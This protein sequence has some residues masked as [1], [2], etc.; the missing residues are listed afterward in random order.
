MA[1]FELGRGFDKGKVSGGIELGPYA[2][3]YSELF[4]DALEDGVITAEERERLDRAADN[5]GMNR[6]QLQQL[7]QAMV[8]AYEMHHRVKVIERW[9]APPASLQPI[10]VDGR[11]DPNS[12]MLLAQIEKL[13]RRVTE[14]EAELR[15]A[16]SQ[17]NVEV[18]LSTFDPSE[19]TVDETPEQLRAR[20]RRDP[21]N[22]KLFSRLYRACSE[23]GDPALETMR[24]GTLRGKES[25][26]CELSS[27]AATAAQCTPCSTALDVAGHCE[28]G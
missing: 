8:N 13:T 25:E 24:I 4:A 1:G 27:L 26:A 5:L 28:M 3:H 10:Q 17:V 7:E 12:Q 20:I 22:P 11:G 6:M 16:R 2:A 15:E 9:E 14:L 21:I 18:D 19:S 23:G